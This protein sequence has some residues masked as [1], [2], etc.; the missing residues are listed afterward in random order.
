MADLERLRA[1]KQRT[2]NTNDSV[3]LKAILFLAQSSEDRIESCGCAATAIRI[4][5]SA[6]QVSRTIPRFPGDS[7]RAL[8]LERF[9]SACALAGQVPSALLHFTLDGPFWRLVEDFMKAHHGRAD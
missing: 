4:T 5:E 1:G 8:R 2:W 7:T 3:P 9:A 6:E